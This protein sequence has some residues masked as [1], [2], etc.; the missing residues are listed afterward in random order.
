MVQI[1]Q[2]LRGPPLFPEVGEDLECE[3]NLKLFDRGRKK[4]GN[5]W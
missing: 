3:R 2:Q 4:L 5:L 1:C